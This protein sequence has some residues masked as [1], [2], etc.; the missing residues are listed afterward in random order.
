LLK[1]NENS[2]IVIID[3]DCI[4]CNYWGNYIISHDLSAQIKITSSKSEIGKELL[5]KTQADPEET[6]ILFFNNEFYFHSNAVIK[7]AVLMKGWHIA[8]KMGY[9]IPKKIRDFL[10]IFISNRRKKIMTNSCHIKD[11]RNKDKFII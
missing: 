7:I 10:Y 8:F 5:K 1:S 11:L 4:F 3:G 9:L 2:T 6:I